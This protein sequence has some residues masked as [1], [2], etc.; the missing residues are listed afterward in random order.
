MSPIQYKHILSSS[1]NTRLSFNFVMNKKEVYEGKCLKTLKI[2]E[3][4][5]TD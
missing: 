2:N 5:V 3:F 1:H 4:I